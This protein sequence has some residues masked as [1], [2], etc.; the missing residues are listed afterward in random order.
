MSESQLGT[1]QYYRLLCIDG[2]GIKGVIPLTILAAFEEATGKRITEMF[3]MVAGTSIG[4]FV[5][6]GLTVP[7]ANGL[8]LTAS[9][10][11]DLLISMGPAIFPNVPAGAQNLDLEGK[12]ALG[13][14]RILYSDGSGL[15]K[16]ANALVKNAILE[17]C[18]V[19][20]LMTSYDIISGKPFIMKSWDIGSSRL[21]VATAIMASGAAP[22]YLPTVTVNSKTYEEELYDSSGIKKQMVLADGGLMGISPTLFALVDFRK[23]LRDANLPVDKILVVSI[24]TGARP[25]V[26][27]YIDPKSVSATSMQWIKPIVS[28]L[29][30]GLREVTAYSAPEFAAQYFRI[31]TT[32]VQGSEIIDCVGKPL[33]DLNMVKL[34]NDAIN[35]TREP[36]FDELVDYFLTVPKTDI[37]TE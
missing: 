17:N 18:L 19:P 27:P 25:L 1:D 28:T 20:T 6:A 8:P 16:F 33:N 4:S 36:D 29:L 35:R 10:A 34:K 31:E 3:N 23:M 13:T 14:T 21:K 9:A 5:A 12:L 30:D 11:C 22:G 26:E 2:G 24:S 37:T 32:L 15:R 7:Q